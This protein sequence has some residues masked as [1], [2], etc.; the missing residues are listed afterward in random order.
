MRYAI[1]YCP[2]VPTPLGRMGQEWLSSST[3][4]DGIS[5]QRRQL[6]LGDAS[7]Y[8]WHATIHA[9]F[10]PVSGASYG[11]VRAAV[12]TLAQT[13]AAF[14]VTL[15]LDR[16]A[17]FLSLRPTI[18]GIRERELA[19]ACLYQLAPLRAPLPEEALACRSL[20]LDAEELSLLRK[21]GY[22]Y[23]L[24]RYRFHLTLAAPTTEFE[25]AAMR[26]WLQPRVAALPPTRIDALAIC[27]EAVPG[28]AFELLEQV[29]LYSGHAP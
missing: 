12:A 23:V 11:D 13:F 24:D 26:Q 16:L 29:S 19:A 3:E 4:V 7:R 27:R 5:T 1:Y 20:G 15:R 28:A 18:D 25:E 21:H 17:G 22:P 2:D 8:G 10:A 9:P 14:E 6:L